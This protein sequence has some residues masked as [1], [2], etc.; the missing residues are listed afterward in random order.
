MNWISITRMQ[1]H[2]SHCHT[3]PSPAMYDELSQFGEL[4]RMQHSFS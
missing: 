2:T 1:N 3:Y 4:I